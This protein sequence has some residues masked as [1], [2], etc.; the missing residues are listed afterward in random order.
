MGGREKSAR[1]T[2][3]KTLDMSVSRHIDGG[4]SLAL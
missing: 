1:E 4:Q 2:E 3:E